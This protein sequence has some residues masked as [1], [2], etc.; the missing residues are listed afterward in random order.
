MPFSVQADTKTLTTTTTIT[1]TLPT[2]VAQFKG[3]RAAVNDEWLQFKA[4]KDTT[5]LFLANAVALVPRNLATTLILSC[6]GYLV[7]QNTTGLG[8]KGRNIATHAFAIAQAPIYFD[9]QRTADV[10]GGGG[11][12]RP[13]ICNIAASKL[14]CYA[15][16]KTQNVIE[17]CP[18]YEEF[19]ETSILL[20]PS[21]GP[22]CGVLEV[23]VTLV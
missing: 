1:K 5:G 18:L 13:L 17:N 8:T 20:G 16:E 23:A 11:G 21:Q 22:Q 15:F 6:E 10:L 4:L 9:Q 14:K 3:G 2:F 12:E 7:Q 19:F